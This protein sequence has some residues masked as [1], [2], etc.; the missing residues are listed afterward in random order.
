M[1]IHINPLGLLRMGK[2]NL[3]RFSSLNALL[4]K[5]QNYDGNIAVPS[6]SYTYT[7]NEVYKINSTPSELGAVS[8]YLRVNN[9]HK[10][11]IDAN[12]S[13]LLFGNG[14]SDK[15][16]EVSN[17]ST[18]GNES[19]IGEVFNKSGYLG[20][21]GGVWE[22]LTEVHYIEKIIKVGYRFDKDFNGITINN[23]GESIDSIITFFCRYLNSDN[24]ACFKRLKKDLMSSGL[25]KTW[26]ISE[27]DLKIEVVKAQDLLLFIKGKILLDSRYLLK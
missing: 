14:F 27:Y 8:E 17:Y 9:A 18:F 3:G 26:K 11:T 7:K 1:I 25:I 22:H 23:R 4:N 2:S 13:Y 6:Y 20:V 19:L 5:V 24:S 21:I 16:L 15:H 12:F 10:R